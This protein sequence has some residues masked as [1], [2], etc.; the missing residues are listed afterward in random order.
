MITLCYM[1]VIIHPCLKPEILN[2][3]YIGISISEIRRP[4][5]RLI[6]GMGIPILVRHL[7]I[8]SGPRTYT[9]KLTLFIHPSP[10]LVPHI[11]VSELGSIGSGNGLSPVRRQAISWT[12][13][14]LLS[15]G[16]LRTNFREIRIKIEKFSCMKMHSKI[17]SAKCHFVQWGNELMVVEVVVV[18]VGVAPQQAKYCK[19]LVSY[20]QVIVIGICKSSSWFMQVIVVVYMQVIAVVY[21]SHSRGICKSS[22]GYMKFIAVVYES[23]RRGLCKS[24]SWYMKV[25]A[26]VHVY[27]SHR[28]GTCIWKSSLW[29]MKVWYMKVIFVVY[30]SHRRGI[31]K[32][33]SRCMQ[34]I[35]VVYVLQRGL[36]GQLIESQ[37]CVYMRE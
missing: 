10:C 22:L 13:V 28:C 18:V 2:Y 27:E 16:P 19:S 30:E 3:Q 33:S 15:I 36:N 7:K 24:S 8:E 17:S 25:I 29:Y 23:H 12:N 20:M 4:Y 5:D 9:N 35:V 31:W 32:S 14:D 34:V 6:S 11:R 37:W 21:E 26:V 1:D